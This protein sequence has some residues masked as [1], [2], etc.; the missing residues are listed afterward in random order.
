VSWRGL[1]ERVDLLLREVARR[2]GA[3]A[4]VLSR[5]ERGEQR[6]TRDVA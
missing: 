5:V 6:A 4:G 1:R 3:D 2:A